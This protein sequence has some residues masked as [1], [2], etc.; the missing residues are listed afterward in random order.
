MRNTDRRHLLRG[1][2]ESCI[3]HQD[4]EWIQ[5]WNGI[6]HMSTTSGLVCGGPR[7]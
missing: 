6:L 2:L 5:R 3:F 7:G 1:S 4:A